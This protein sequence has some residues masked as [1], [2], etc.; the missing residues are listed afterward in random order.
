MSRMKLQ[1][2]R[3]ALADLEDDPNYQSFC[4]SGLD[5][6]FNSFRQEVDMT[7]IRCL[8]IADPNFCSTSP[9]YQP[10]SGSPLSQRR[11]GGAVDDSGG[12]SG[13]VVVI[14]LEQMVE[15]PVGRDV[16]S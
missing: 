14:A 13:I 8:Q 2:V 10:R 16:Q 6:R 7:G 5:G 9:H 3:A 11:L 12:I 15:L 1:N 4:D